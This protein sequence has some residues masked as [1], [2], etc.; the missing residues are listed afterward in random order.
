MNVIVVTGWLM[1][2]ADV[3][4]AVS[5][6]KFLVFEAM[7]RA[8]GDEEDTP[9]RCEIEDEAEIAHA[10]PML[11]A[12]RGVLLR[13]QLAGKPFVKHGVRSGFA[14]FLRVEH[15]QF[16]RAD[17]AKEK[18]LIPTEAAEEAEAKP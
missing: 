7:L 11:T 3:A 9:W 2:G 17:R 8:D 4:Y 12:G 16:V 1:K 5:G 10:E 6:R 14:R 18:E 15:V 13:A